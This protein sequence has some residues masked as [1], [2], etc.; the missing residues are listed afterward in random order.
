MQHLKKAVQ[1]FLE[2]GEESGAMMPEV[3]KLVEW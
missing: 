2:I 3:W 1:I